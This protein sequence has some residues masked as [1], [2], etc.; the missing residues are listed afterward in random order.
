MR[1]FTICRLLLFL[2]PGKAD[3]AVFLSQK[4]TRK[5]HINLP[6]LKAV[7]SGIRKKHFSLQGLVSPPSPIRGTMSI[8]DVIPREQ[9]QQGLLGAWKAR[10]DLNTTSHSPI[11]PQ[12]GLQ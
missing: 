6:I 8:K 7:V 12:E 4:A 11:Q 2:P 10:L 5:S 9:R 3:S 1:S